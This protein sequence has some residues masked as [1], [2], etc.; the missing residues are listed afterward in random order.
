MKKVT[1]ATVIVTVIVTIS[2]SIGNIF[3]TGVTTTGDQ[4][5][6]VQ[7]EQPLEVLIKNSG[8][9]TS[10]LTG[11]YF[12][13]ADWQTT[14]YELPDYPYLGFRLNQAQQIINP[15]FWSQN[16]SPA[17][18][19]L[20]LLET[21]PA[22]DHLFNQVNLDILGVYASFSDQKLHFAIKNNGNGF[23][24]GSGLTFYSYMVILVNPDADPDADPIVF[25]LMYTISIPGAISPGL[26][27]ITGTGTSDLENIGSIEHVID[28][29][30]NLLILS[31]NISDLLADADF[32]SWFDPSAPNP[33][34]IAQAISSRI[35]LTGGTQTS[36]QT[37]G[38]RVIIKS[39]EI[40]ASNLN[41]PAPDDAQIMAVD[42]SHYA[43]VS[44]SDPDHNFPLQADVFIDET[45]QYPLSPQLPYNYDS[46]VL[47]SSPLFTL[48]DNWEVIRFRFSDDD[49]SFTESFIYNDVNNSDE[50][51]PAQ[52]NTLTLYPN[53]STNKI[54]IKSSIPSGGFYLLNIYNVR[55]QQISTRPLVFIP[56]HKELEFDASKLVP[57][58]YFV[59]LQSN[60]GRFLSHAKFVKR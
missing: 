54:W 38:T 58:V 32:S 57:G 59:T 56:D 2:A 40:Q 37:A 46:V 43:T 22:S 44:Y 52:T 21:D 17:F 48:P 33:M 47:F 39:R 34:L 4:S 16:T 5:V 60:T 53:P 12:D 41:P 14:S 15:V 30:N 55:G 19:D 7:A 3:Y 23:P 11:S 8:A 9:I 1:L 45:D 6:L 42:D 49:N 18:A 10:Y 29:D 25:G 51:M 31:C 26:Y 35:T 24:T 13:N 36:D 20:T 28:S 50:A 27:K